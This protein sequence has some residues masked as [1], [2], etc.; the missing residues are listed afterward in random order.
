ML[1]LPFTLDWDLAVDVAIESLSN[2][3]GISY[4]YATSLKVN[5]ICFKL[6][7]TYSNPTPSFRQML[8]NLFWGLILKDFIEVQEK[9]KKVVSCVFAFSSKRD[10]RPHFHVAVLQ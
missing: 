2:K 7:R 8:V 6:F 4:D 10:L 5:S 1:L 3:D 9:K